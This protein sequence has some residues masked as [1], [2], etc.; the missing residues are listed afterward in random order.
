LLAGALSLGSLATDVAES[1]RLGGD[2]WAVLVAGSAGYGNY[3]HQSDVCHAYQIVI[4][5]G[6]KP[7]QVIVLAVDDI[8]GDSENPYPG[9]M[10]NK[11][12]PAGTPGVDVYAGCNIDYSGTDVTPETF[13]KVL[14]GDQ[15]ANGKVLESTE[16]SRVFVNFVDHGGVGLIGF[17]ETTMHA[18]ELVGA[19][20]KMSD[21]SM[22]K[23]LVF[24]LEACESGSMFEDLPSDIKI[25]AQTASNAKESSWGTYCSPDDKVDGK[26]I[27]SCLGD[28]YSVSWME[29]SDSSIASGETLAEQFTKVVALTNK[30]HVMEYGDTTFK[31]QPVSNYQ[32][33]TDQEQGRLAMVEEVARPKNYAS[34]ASPNAE[35]ASAYSRFMENDSEKAGLEL[36]Q[37]I[38]DRITAKK[39]FEKIAVAVTGRAAT[40]RRPERVDMK[41][42]YAAHVAYKTKCGEWTNGALRHS[43]T[44]AEM[45]AATNGDPRSIVAAITEACAH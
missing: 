45:C 27:M 24:Y 12:T 20:Q 14:T 26:S 30:S 39:V 17:P 5:A 38:Q 37:G 4:N 22:Y 34:L 32:G 23:E 25:Y 6:M 21:S 31:S 11:P 2:H 40:G 41:C 43:A 13:V 44:L 35:L 16:K 18:T 33:K 9:K 19:L 7:E 42:H 8:A 28:L 10:F 3:R 29:D 1:V 36:I 15:T